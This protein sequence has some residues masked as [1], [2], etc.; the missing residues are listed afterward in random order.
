[1]SPRLLLHAWLCAAAVVLFVL[2]GCSGKDDGKASCGKRDLLCLCK[3]DC[4]STCSSDRSH[5]FNITSMTEG[6]ECASCL[7][8]K[9]PQEARKLCPQSDTTICNNCI[10]AGAVCWAT[11]WP[12]CVKQ[13]L[14]WW[15]PI[16]CAQC[17]LSNYTSHCLGEYEKCFD[18][19][20]ASTSLPSAENSM[21]G[22]QN[23]SS[24]LAV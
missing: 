10:T 18:T 24:V 14:Q 2:Q 22:G 17:W 1:M 6:K 12:T 11:T 7:T 15:D 16:E 3:E 8:S 20:D 9:C 4:V 19:K 13:C 5:N 23:T 21:A